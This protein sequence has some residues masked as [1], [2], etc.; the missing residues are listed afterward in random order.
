MTTPPDAEASEFIAFLNRE[1]AAAR[2]EIEK[3]GQ[4]VGIL[5]K[6]R[7]DFLSQPGD[8]APEIRHAS[9]QAVATDAIIHFLQEHDEP[10][11]TARI[12]AYIESQGINFGGRQPRNALSVLL[13]RSSLFKAHGRRGWTLASPAAHAQSKG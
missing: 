11:P 7:E 6:L 1:I 13:S 5:T 12:L 10:V 2:G 3:L 8:S 4:K 9:R